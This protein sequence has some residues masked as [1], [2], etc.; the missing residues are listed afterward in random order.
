MPKRESVW[1]TLFVFFLTMTG[2]LAAF[3]LA[4][5]LEATFGLVPAVTIMCAL[6][7]LGLLVPVIFRA[8]WKLWNDG[9]SR[10]A[11]IGERLFDISELILLPI[12]LLVS[13]GASW[14]LGAGAIVA[15][16]FIIGLLIAGIASL[17][18]SAAIIIG[19]LIISSSNK[20]R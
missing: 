12:G 5:F 16:I 4:N 3:A 14:I 1:K 9:K 2:V 10:G 11:S 8:A 17:P 15:A 6:L 19:A 18:V 20:R 13:K 7:I